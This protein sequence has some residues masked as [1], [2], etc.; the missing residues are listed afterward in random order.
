MPLTNRQSHLA[1]RFQELTAESKRIAADLKLIKAEISEEMFGDA[2]IGTN[3]FELG[4]GWSIK[5]VVGESYTLDKDNDK[6]HE[7]QDNLED[8]IADKVITWKPTL[9]KKAY[10]MLSPEDKATVDSVLTTKAKPTTFAI[11]EP[12]EEK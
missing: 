1:S 5:A 4:N 11:V 3:T 7:V 8:H 12:K 10:D 6:I 9:S 2:T